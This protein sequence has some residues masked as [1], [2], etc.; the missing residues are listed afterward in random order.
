[1]RKLPLTAAEE[2]L[3]VIMRRH[4][5]AA[6][7]LT[8]ARPVEDWGKLLGDTPAITAMLDRLLRHGD[9]SGMDRAHL[10]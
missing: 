3:E 8:S 9:V 5:R 10:R 7:L 2:L 6:T 4:E 1:M